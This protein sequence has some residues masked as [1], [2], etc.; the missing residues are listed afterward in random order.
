MFIVEDERR[1]C[2]II[3]VHMHFYIGSEQGDYLVC[4][5]TPAETSIMQMVPSV[6]VAKQCV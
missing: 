3:E 6:R 4:P 1:S 5:P 2:G